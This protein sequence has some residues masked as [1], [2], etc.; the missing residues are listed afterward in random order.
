MKNLLKLLGIT[1]IVAGI[2]FSMLG[3]AL[4]GRRC[5][6]SGQCSRSTC[7]VQKFIAQNP[8]DWWLSSAAAR[9]PKCDCTG[10]E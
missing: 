1:V 10:N 3:C 8:D 7:A 2:G 9:M 6:A 5:D 4:C